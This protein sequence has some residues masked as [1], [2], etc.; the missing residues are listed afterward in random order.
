MW[1]LS[2]VA[3]GG[4][5]APHFSLWRLAEMLGAF[6][7]GLGVSAHALDELNGHPLRT[8]LSDKALKSAGTVG[9]IGA[10]ALG[11]KGVTEVGVWL[12]PFIAIGVGAVLAYNLEWFGGRF[13]TDAAFAASWGAFPVLV[14]YFVEA[15]R[16]DVTAAL[17]AVAAYGLSLAQRTLSTETR[18]LR[19][20]VHQAHLHLELSEG[21][22]R[23][24]GRAELLVPFDAALKTMSWAM[25]AL[26]G[27]L[28][29]ARIK[30]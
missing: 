13:H 21:E 17:V 23:E 24:A 8:Q 18:F 5:I 26:A 16:L 7:L 14:G 6:L 3:M 25:V 4:A 12:V 15:Q 19:R 2:Y 27:G 28:V 30:L 11:I 29:L 22:V 20:R 10:V 1:N 9:L